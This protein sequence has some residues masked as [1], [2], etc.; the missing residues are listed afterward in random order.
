[1]KGR[2]VLEWIENANCLDADVYIAGYGDE[3]EPATNIM[4]ADD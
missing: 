2:D 3:A 1:M 4:F